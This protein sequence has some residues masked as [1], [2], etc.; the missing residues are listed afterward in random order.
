MVYGFARPCAGNGACTHVCGSSKVDAGGSS[1]LRTGGAG[2]RAGGVCGRAAAV[3]LSDTETDGGRH[4]NICVNDSARVRGA[5]SARSPFGV[6]PVAN[7]TGCNSRVARGRNRRINYRSYAVTLR[8]AAGRPSNT[9]T[10]TRISSDASST[11]GGLA[12][13][14]AG[15]LG[16]RAGDIDGA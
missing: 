3:A 16:Q 15:V 2:D 13:L 9:P 14:C 4:P 11:S 6:P 7:R 12:S 1:C 8:L 10:T 5:T